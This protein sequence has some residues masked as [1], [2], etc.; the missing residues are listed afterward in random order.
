MEKPLPKTV[1]ERDFFQ[2][3]GVAFKEEFKAETG[4]DITSAT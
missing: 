1:G 3:V 4:Q 2:Q